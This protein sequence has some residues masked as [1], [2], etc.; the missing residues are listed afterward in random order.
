ML[1]QWKL[2]PRRNRRRERNQRGEHDFR[3]R[4]LRLESLEDRRLLAVY[5]SDDVPLSIPDNG[6]SATSALVVPDAIAISDIN[7]TLDISHTRDA[8]VDAFLIGPD[9]TRVELFTDVGGNGYHFQA[10]SLDDEAGMAITSGSAPF[11]GSF[12][13]EG[14]LSDFDGRSAQG[15]WT[16]EITD[17][18]RWYAGTLNSWSIEVTS[19]VPTLSIDDVAELEGESGTTPFTFTVTRTGD[20]SGPSSVDYYTDDGSAVAGEDYV[21]QSGKIEFDGG[22]ASQTIVVDVTGDTTI[23][24]GESFTV[25]LSNPINASITDARGT[26]TILDDDATPTISFS[27]FSDIS[28]LTLVNSADTVVTATGETVLRLTPPEVGRV[29]AAW[30]TAEKQYVTVAFE[31]T[32][33]FQLTENYD[34][35]GGSDGFTFVIQNAGPDEVRGSGGNLAYRSL[36]NSLVIEFD[37]FLN[38]NLADPSHSHISVHTRGPDYNSTD[39]AFSLG[40]YDTYS[41]GVQLD[42]TQVHTARISYVPGNLTVALDDLGTVLSV[43]VDLEETLDLDVG[44]AW[45]G[46]TA[47]TG[48]GWQNHDILNWVFRPLVDT[49]TAIG[50]DDVSQVESHAGTTDF[51]FTVSR[52][53]DLSDSTVVNW[54]IADDSATGGSDYSVVAPEPL[55]FAPLETTK[56]IVVPVMGDPSEEDHETFVVNLSV[57]DPTSGTIV[58]GQGRGTILNDD[59]SVSISDASVTEGHQSIRFLDDFIAAGSGGLSRPRELVLGPDGRLY[60]SAD[61]NFILRY[62]AT[63]GQFIDTFVSSQEGGLTGPSGMDFDSNG[64]LYVASRQTHEILRYD[65]NGN[66]VNVF[67]SVDSP[68]ALAIGPDGDVYVTSHHQ[69]AVYRFDVNSDGTGSLDVS[70]P[71][72]GTTSLDNPQGLV[73]D[74]VGRLYVTSHNS[75]EVLRHDPATDTFEVFVTAQSGGLDGPTHLA[76]GPDGYLYVSSNVTNSVLRYDGESGA[77][78]D[79]YIAPGLGGIAE[80]QGMVFDQLGNLYVSSAETD[81]VLRYGSASQAV[82]TVSLSQSSGAPVTLDFATQPGTASEG[83]DYARVSGT[84]VFDPGVTE[85]TILVPLAPDDTVEEDNE[86]F[87]VT[88]S[89]PTAGTI[90]T[91]A[92]GTATILDNDAAPDPNMLYVYDIRFESKRGN[93][94]W[95][96]VFEIRSDSNADGQGNTADGVAAGVEI[97][98]EFAGQTYTGATDSSGVFRTDWIRNPGSGDHYAEVVD[99]V[100]AGY[101][102]NPLIMDLEDDT[103]G[104]GK[105]DD[106][107]IL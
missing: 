46:F 1:S 62:D 93:Q 82:F 4:P 34:D 10:T 11:S 36:P 31:T 48:G 79:A 38:A 107:L 22:Q 58:D 25:V 37:T 13:P 29:G 55:S 41:D 40:T 7:V 63:T 83:S 52:L 75:D 33:Q 57:A 45:V 16:L 88:I 56:Q 94:D 8:D 49:T 66:F 87:E 70:W 32:F 21:G 95:R 67:A 5:A 61:A 19:A 27:D 92:S 50:I 86:T 89:N 9:G 42:D 77:F 90:I 102:W 69:D 68:T 18:R 54:T 35:P 2:P 3:R 43:P 78:I 23:E 106:V 17:D 80:A 15:T 74:T 85:R 51:V 72:G 98:V 103:D 71:L 104:D 101:F 53:G 39:E 81:E 97:T 100:L 24:P 65:A 60:I 64:N 28:G 30:Y 91:D 20:I 59:T 47:A 12:R 96:A 44:R 6:G 99:L 73:F 84:L 105:P 26:A 76:I 14:S